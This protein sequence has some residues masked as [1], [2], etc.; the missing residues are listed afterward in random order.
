MK[1][2]FI[3]SVASIIFLSGF[4]FAQPEFTEI[5]SKVGAFSRMGFGARGIGMGNAMSSVTTGNVVSYYNPA[6]TPFPFTR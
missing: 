5:N 3:L 1:N 6:V 4:L 2:K